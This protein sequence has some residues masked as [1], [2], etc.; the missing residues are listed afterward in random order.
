MLS[1]GLI[2]LLAQ[3]P[4]VVLNL[5][6][7]FIDLKQ[8]PCHQ[9]NFCL[10][11]NQLRQGLV[12]LFLISFQWRWGNLIDSLFYENVKILSVALQS[13]FVFQMPGFHDTTDLF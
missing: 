7:Q 12:R 13:V 2:V 3:Q 9:V 8:A 11:S 1:Y 5:T 4:R 6:K 10:H